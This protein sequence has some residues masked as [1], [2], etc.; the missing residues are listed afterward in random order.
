MTEQKAGRAASWSLSLYVVTAKNWKSQSLRDLHL[1]P[2][3]MN[4]SPL[5]TDTPARAPNNGTKTLLLPDVFTAGGADVSAKGGDWGGGT[6]ETL[7]SM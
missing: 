5:K 3:I 1:P 7:K 4:N 2:A 6:G